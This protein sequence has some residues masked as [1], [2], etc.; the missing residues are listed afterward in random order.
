MYVLE[1]EAVGSPWIL[2]ANVGDVGRLNYATRILQRVPQDKLQQS[3]LLMR[4]G[5]KRRI[6]EEIF[7]RLNL[8][9]PDGYEKRAE[10]RDGGKEPFVLYAPKSPQQ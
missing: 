4:P 5:A 9:F 1:A 8:N 7:T 6:S 2:S 3:W 10:W